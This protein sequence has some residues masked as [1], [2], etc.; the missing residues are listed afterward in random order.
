[1]AGTAATTPRGEKGHSAGALRVPNFRLH[2]ASQSVSQA[3]TWLQLVALSWLAFELTGS[4]TALGWIAAAT[5][6]PFLVVGPWA[7]ALADR[8]D[9][10][11]LLAVVQLLAAVPAAALGVL[12]LTGLINTPI[13]VGIALVTG[14]IHAVENPVRH[15]FVS[16]LVEHPLVPAA[17]SLTSAVGAAARVLGP[18]GAGAVLVTADI[19]WCFMA[20]AVSH[21][22]ALACLLA[23]RRRQLHAIPGGGEDAS[24]AA[25]LRYAWRVPELRTALLLTAVVATFGFNHQVLMPLLA[26]RTFAGDAGTYTLLYSA[27]SI[28]AL[29]G[30]LVAARRGSVD[31]RFLG[32]ATVGFG[33]ATGL[34][35]LAP[36][37]PI[38]V[39][40]GAVSGAAGLL[41]VASATALLQQRSDPAMRGRV[42]ALA[43][44]VIV[45]GHPV[46]GPIVG[47]VA[48][49]TGPRSGLALAAVVALTAGAA[50]L[51]RLR[52]PT[53]PWRTP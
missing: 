20:N 22:V 19:G 48:E 30:A 6:G 31:I 36:T 32:R 4:G 29:L 50:V 49:L 47:W 16:E 33:A 38:A 52:S 28:G 9:Q 12:A 35:A 11:R 51:S 44:M 24:V 34:L 14:V 45:G 41:F 8:V 53:R 23:M 7:G 13:L 43:A 21:L 42:M 27:M 5:F 1:M 18:L 2:L 26:H 3:G 25:G 17:V 15:A 46:G 40:A 10:L 39:L 37:L